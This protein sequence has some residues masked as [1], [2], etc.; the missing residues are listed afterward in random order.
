MVCCFADFSM[1]SLDFLRIFG[2]KFL[3]SFI[4]IMCSML[5]VRSH[6]AGMHLSIMR[7]RFVFTQIMSLSK[8]LTLFCRMLTSVFI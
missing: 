6:F 5:F 2:I 4:I 1:I 8:M 7:F 3:S